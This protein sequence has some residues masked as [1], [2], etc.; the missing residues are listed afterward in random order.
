MRSG[1]AASNFR[2]SVARNSERSAFNVSRQASV[3]PKI[4]QRF[5][6]LSARFQ[7]I[8]PTV[9]SSPRSKIK[10][11][12]CLHASVA[13]VFVVFIFVSLARL[14]RASDVLHTVCQAASPLFRARAPAWVSRHGPG[15]RQCAHSLGIVMAKECHSFRRAGTVTSRPVATVPRGLV[16]RAGLAT[17]PAETVIAAGRVTIF[18]VPRTRACLVTILGVESER[19]I[20]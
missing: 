17:V 19:P 12:N 9:A 20:Y 13:A 11:A 10:P 14:R 18:G 4:F 16:I 3:H 7:M 2:L 15:P 1:K 6:I 5:S 8:A